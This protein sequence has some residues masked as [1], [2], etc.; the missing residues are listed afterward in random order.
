MTFVINAD[1]VT[2]SLTLGSFQGT[3]VRN[4][5]GDYTITFRNAY[6][7]APVAMVTGAE[8]DTAGYYA[9]AGVAS[10]DVLITDLA[11]AA[12]DNDVVVQVIGWDAQ[13]EV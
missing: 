5:A 4:G 10:I 8:A 9:N 6:G 11:A 3:L 7:R 12:A 13:D 2:P 1:A